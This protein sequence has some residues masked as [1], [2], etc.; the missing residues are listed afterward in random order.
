M[1]YFIHL[2]LLFSCCIQ[3]QTKEAVLARVSAEYAAARPLQFTAVYNLYK[4]PQ[5]KTIA[6]TYKGNFYKN[7]ANEIYLKINTTEYFA[8]K[9]INIQVNHDEKA[10]LVQKPQAIPQDQF[11]ITKLLE[12]FQHGYFKDQK[13]YWEME[14]LAKKSSALPY[15]KIVIRIGKDY[16]IQ[17]QVFYYSTAIN[18]SKDYT[19]RDVHK[20]KLEITFSKA[21]RESIAPGRFDTTPYITITKKGIKLSEKFSS[22]E[23]IDQR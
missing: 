13:T 1:K 3:A 18:F 9:K 7:A 11:N 20:P 2:I 5:S 21:S 4:D 23:L 16:F 6:E 22:Y 12:T 10:I 14:L 8:T 17:K 15:S 19:K